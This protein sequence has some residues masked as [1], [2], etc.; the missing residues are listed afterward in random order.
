M[1]DKGII[2]SINSYAGD[3]EAVVKAGGA[4]ASLKDYFQYSIPRTVLLG[5]SPGTSQ[6]LT[7]PFR[8]D[9][10][11]II[12]KMFAKATSTFSV[13]MRNDADGRYFHSPSALINDVN[14]FG[15]LQL[16]NKLL[17]PIIVPPNATLSF[18]LAD[19]SGSDNTVQITLCG[20]RLYDFT[21]PPI[22]K[23]NGKRTGWFQ[24]VTDKVLTASEGP[25]QV[26]VKVDADA[27]FLVRKLVATST[28][29]FTAK[30]ADAGT[31]DYWSD[32]AQDNANL[33]GT[34]QYPLIL[35]KPKLVKAMGSLLVEMTD[36]SVASN[37]IQIVAEGIKVYK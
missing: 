6:I 8:A 32:Q 35:P 34:A 9:S 30:L 21:N 5:G 14:L 22:P 4:R 10:Y 29:A 37:T 31:N 18:V 15:T 7:I 12:T 1:N 26:L 23:T 27:D 19:T 24:L 33:F 25:T 13:Q 20:Y 16:P 17:D 3:A 2:A 28:G 11:F 36:L